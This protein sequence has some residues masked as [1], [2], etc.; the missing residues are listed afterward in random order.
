MACELTDHDIDL[1]AV[2]DRRGRHRDQQTSDRYPENVMPS[3]SRHSHQLGNAEEPPQ[4]AMTLLPVCH[5]L[6]IW[7]AT[8]RPVE[9]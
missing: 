6:A 7:Q 8:Y 5:I 2:S 3:P 9:L 4:F 1:D